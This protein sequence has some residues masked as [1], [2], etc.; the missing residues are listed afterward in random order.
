MRKILKRAGITLSVLLLLLLSAYIIVWIL[1]NRRINKQYTVQVRP[2]EIRPDSAMLAHG[3][4]LYI[5]KGCAD[6]HGANLSGR[7]FVDDPMIGRFTGANLTKGRGGLPADFDDKAWLMAL[8]H[9][10]S[11]DGKSLLIMPS[12]EYALLA[13]Y[14]IASLIAW[15]K[16][17]A[18]VDNQPPAMRVGPMGRVLTLF[19]KIPL[20]PAEKVDHHYQQPAVVKQE[21]SAAYGKY[22]SVSCTGC[23]HPD[24]RGGD[25]P[26]PGKI[27]V[28]DITAKGHIGKWTAS[29]FITTLR[30]GRTPEGKQLNNE[31]M[32]WKT[33]AQYTEQEL[34]ALY[35]YLRSL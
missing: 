24:L 29:Q 12:Y 15:C 6:C 2:L 10:L 20:L 26:I 18:P 17:Q 27:A 13:D 7:V 34:E 19:G 31:D 5:T 25:N 21:V 22:L 32:P 4:R 1:S 11:P 9:G 14:D 8:R 28:A 3:A 35:L 30:T 33:T 16:M 23:H